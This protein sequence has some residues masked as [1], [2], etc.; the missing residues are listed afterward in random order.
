LEFDHRGNKVKNVSEMLGSSCTWGTIL[1][2]INKCDVRCSNCHKI[3]TAKDF[4]WY[5][6]II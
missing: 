6:N 1:K 2:E 4:G 3:K 5:K